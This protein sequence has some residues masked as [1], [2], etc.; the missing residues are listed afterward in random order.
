[1]EFFEN[2][3]VYVNLFDYVV[4]IFG[5]ALFL[6]QF[7]ILIMIKLEDRH[8]RKLIKENKPEK[9][10]TIEESERHRLIWIKAAGVIRE[11]IGIL[12]FA[13][14][15]GTVLGLLNTLTAFSVGTGIE[16][17]Q[18]IV[19]FAPALTST[20]SAI[21]ATIINSLLFNFML[22]PKIIEQDEELGW[23]LVMKK[24]LEIAE[25]EKYLYLDHL[26]E[27]D[28]INKERDKEERYRKL[29][30]EKIFSKEEKDKINTEEQ[31]KNK[32]NDDDND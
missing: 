27:L 22:L 7:F 1:M 16:I 10:R 15:L 23:D 5:G 32:K 18:I 20:I 25:N 29:A 21:I 26:K 24:S 14:I 3:F 9:M 31:S 30:S 17:T 6:V 28:R 11:T 13:G 8:K 19:E 12:P 2:Y 4:I